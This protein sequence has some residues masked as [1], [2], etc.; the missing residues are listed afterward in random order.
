MINAVH[1]LNSMNVRN[2]NIVIAFSQLTEIN[3]LRQLNEE[4]RF[5]HLTHLGKMS[6]F[7]GCEMYTDHPNNGEIIIYDRMDIRRERKIVVPF[8]ARLK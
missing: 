5:I 1:E 2:E 8:E 4:N 6:K 7:M 3:L